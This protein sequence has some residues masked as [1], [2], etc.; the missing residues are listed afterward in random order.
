MEMINNFFD[1]LELAAEKPLMLFKITKSL[2]DLFKVVKNMSEEEY[3]KVIFS[4]QIRFED[5]EIF[6]IISKIFNA[7]RGE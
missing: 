2:P 1:L 4:A 5:P 7:M 6:S 3:E